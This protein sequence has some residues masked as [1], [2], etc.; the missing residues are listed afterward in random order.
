[1]DSAVRILFHLLYCYV[2]YRVSQN[3]LHQLMLYFKNEKRNYQLIPGT[4]VGF[5]QSTRSRPRHSH[6]FLIF[7]PIFE[8]EWR[9][10]TYQKRT[11]YVPAKYGPS[12]KPIPATSMRVGDPVTVRIFPKKPSD[13]RIEEEGYFWKSRTWVTIPGIILGS[14]MMV[15]GFYTLFASLFR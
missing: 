8:Y 12:L 4:I 3:C 13:A 7:Y 9:G 1:M 5:Q 11:R 6:R 14:A 10:K 15:F 2:G